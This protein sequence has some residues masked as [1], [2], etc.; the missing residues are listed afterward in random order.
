MQMEQIQ[1][2][3]SHLQQHA[4]NVKEQKEMLAAQ[5]HEAEQKFENVRV[6][7]KQLAIEIQALRQSLQVHPTTIT[8]LWFVG[9]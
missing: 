7:N 4:V 5:L 2:H 8:A 1:A 6:E 9:T 3:N